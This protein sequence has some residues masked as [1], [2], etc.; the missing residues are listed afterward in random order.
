[1]DARSAQA[2]C[3]SPDANPLA[4]QSNPIRAAPSAPNHK[5]TSR[6]ETIGAVFQAH[7]KPFNQTVSTFS[8]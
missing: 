7:R 5:R 3:A 1:M 4:L 8:E 2:H 6:R